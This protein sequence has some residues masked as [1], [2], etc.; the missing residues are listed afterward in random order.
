M[1]LHEFLIQNV[2]FILV[3]LSHDGRQIPLTIFEV[4]LNT[5]HEEKKKSKAGHQKGYACPYPV[6]LNTVLKSLEPL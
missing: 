5:R 6:A 2:L 3:A 4:M 1:A